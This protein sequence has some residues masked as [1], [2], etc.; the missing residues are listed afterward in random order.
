MT[1]YEMVDGEYYEQGSDEYYAALQAITA[2]V[3][4]VSVLIAREIKRPDSI[5]NYANVPALIVRISP[6]AE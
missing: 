1:A 6:R 4:D 2:P 3:I 5:G